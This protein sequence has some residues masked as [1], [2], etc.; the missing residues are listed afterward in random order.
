MKNVY[1]AAVA[2]LAFAFS[3]C[4]G[5]KEEDYGACYFS[6]ILMENF[7]DM[8][9]EG[10]KA[11]PLTPKDCEEEL[12]EFDAMPETAGLF[13]VKFMDSCPSGYKLKCKEDDGTLYVYG[14]HYSNLT[15][16]DLEEN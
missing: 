2:L 6:L 7:S 3:A 12:A 14:E 8:C 1:F 10:D 5:D 9:G 11:N 15:C 13:S 16:A 4:S